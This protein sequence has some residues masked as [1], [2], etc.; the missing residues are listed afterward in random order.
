MKRFDG[1]LLKRMRKQRGK[2]MRDLA[3][4][5][6]VAVPTVQEYE[7][8]RCVPNADRLALIAEV[9]QL[10]MTEICGLLRYVP[11]GISRN[12]LEKFLG[13]CAREQVN[14]STV[15]G[16]MIKGYMY[17]WEQDGPAVEGVGE[18][19][20]ARSGGRKARLYIPSGK[21]AGEVQPAAGGAGME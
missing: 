16:S 19:A 8:G 5:I 3:N 4:R 11:A 15:I 14:A 20:R 13:K 6:G 12:T 21:L 2:S 1:E 10:G 9:L 17:E 7:D 18:K